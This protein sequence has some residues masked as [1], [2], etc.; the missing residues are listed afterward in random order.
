[1]ITEPQNSLMSK[2]EFK[3]T[4]VEKDKNPYQS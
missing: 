4:C 1:M 2:Q 3:M